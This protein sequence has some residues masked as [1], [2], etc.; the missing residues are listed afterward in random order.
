MNNT[1]NLICFLIALGLS[2]AQ[3]TFNKLQASESASVPGKVIPATESGKLYLPSKDAMADV[4]AAMETAREDNK[5]L[6]V[7][8]GANWCHD[9]RAL[10]SRLHKEPLKTLIDE[11]YETILVDVGYLENGKDVIT[12]LGAPVYYATPTILIVNPK[13]GELINDHNRHQ[14]AEA[15]S[16]QMQDSVDYFQQFANTDQDTSASLKE[17]STRLQEL[18]LE[19]EAFEQ[20]QADRL[21]AAYAV[22]SPMLRAYEGGNKEAFSESHWSEVRDFRYQVPKD[23][24]S[25][26]AEA[27]E[28]VNSGETEINLQYP[29]YPPF[30]WETQAQ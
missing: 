5:P 16:I 23:V 8:F 18:L 17:P 19:I 15:A 1:K 26:Q 27:V 11:N 2:T 3:L 22:L 21:Y 10:A 30:S 12:S 6:L 24:D 25:L 28:R 20:L 13:N 7:V 14:W 4:S 29:Q 9:S